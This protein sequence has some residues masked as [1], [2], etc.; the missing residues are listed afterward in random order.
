MTISVSQHHCLATPRRPIRSGL[1]ICIHVAP[2]DINKLINI[3]PTHILMCGCRKCLT[4]S[5][6]AIYEYWQVF[7]SAHHQ[8]VLVSWAT[9]SHRFFKI[10]FIINLSYIFRLLKLFLSPDFFTKCYMHF[11]SIPFV[12]HV[13]VTV[14][15][16]ALLVRN[17]VYLLKARTVEPEKQTLLA[18]GSKTTFVSRQP[19][20]NKQ[21]N[22]VRC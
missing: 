8:T 18:N 19:P 13:P 20:R 10:S 15:W 1:Q 3:R 6:E 12:I 7:A 11:S 2:I 17:V 5:G 22:N 21:Q 16:V 4:C 14:K 9:L